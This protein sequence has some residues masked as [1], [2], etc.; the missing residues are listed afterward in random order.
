MSELNRLKVVDFTC[1]RLDSDDINTDIPFT[2]NFSKTRTIQQANAVIGAYVNRNYKDMQNKANIDDIP[3]KVSELDNDVGYITNAD[4]PTKTS[5]LENDSGFITSADLPTKVSEL[6]NDSGFITNTVDD[7]TNYTDNDTLTGL[8][9]DKA[10]KTDLD[11]VK[12]AIDYKSTTYIGDV[13]VESVNSKNMFNANNL[14]ACFF[15]NNNKII[16]NNNWRIT[17]LIPVKPSTKYT[18]SRSNGGN[19]QFLFAEYDSSKTF[20]TKNSD[21]FADLSSK[22]YTTGSTTHYVIVGYNI[23]YTNNEMQ[24]EKGIVRTTYTPFQE[25][26]NSDNYCS[27]EIVIGNWIDSK[28][29]YRKCFTSDTY[30]TSYSIPINNIQTIT[31]IVGMVRRSDYDIWQ[32]LPSRIGNASFTAQFENLAFSNT[33]LTVNVTWGTSWSSALSKINIIVEYTK[34]TD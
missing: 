28:P 18:L 22:T 32:V 21:W 1:G 6:D 5:D 27:D 3:T 23:S 15:D 33:A 19:G 11:N 16:A 4:I 31:N 30:N 20:I 2:D 13:T 34:T 7:L 14:K 29:I 8:L 17:T 9:N 12:S 24:F 25:I 10:N 26:T